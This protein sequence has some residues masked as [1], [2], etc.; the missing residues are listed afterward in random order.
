MSP[1][2]TTAT[3]IHPQLVRFIQKFREWRLGGT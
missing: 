1:S 3:D 2:M